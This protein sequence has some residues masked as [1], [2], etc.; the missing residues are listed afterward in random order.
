MITIQ[1]KH[2]Q[3]GILPETGASIA[4]GRVRHNDQWVDVLRP[5]PLSDYGNSSNCS[6]FIM[7]PWCNRIKDGLLR[8]GDETFQLNVTKDDGTARHG[9]VRKR[10]WTVNLID[11]YHISMSLNSSDFPDM[12]WPFAFSALAEYRLDGAEFK[13]TLSIKNEDTRAYPTGFGHHPY[14]VKPKGENLPHVQIPCNQYF[15]LTNYMA[16]GPAVDLPERLEFREMRSLGEANINDV[17]TYRIGDEP[18]RMYY[19]EY[20]TTLEMFADPLFKHILLYAP[21]G[22]PYYAVEPMTNVSDGFNLF[23][24]DVEGSGVFVLEI[25]EEQRADVRLIVK[26]S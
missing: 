9:D 25:G 3:I 5:T 11:A 23:A 8:Y 1:N 21:E 22:E 2:W 6:S 26:Q 13:W 15:E 14:F 18:A 17:L 20:Q 10:N 4:F 12:N 19:P 7:L 16:T 24:D